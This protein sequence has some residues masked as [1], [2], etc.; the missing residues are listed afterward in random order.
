MISKMKTK[1]KNSMK[2]KYLLLIPLILGLVMCINFVLATEPYYDSSYG[3]GFEGFLNYANILVNG[4]F[5]NVFLALIWIVTVYTL[6]KS[7]WKMPGILSFAFFITFITA[8]IMRLF[9]TSM[10]ELVLFM[11]G[12]G[13]AISVFWAVIMDRT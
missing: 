10:N 9:I 12:V 4:W 8:M 11:L 2:K 13:L 7:E 5:V 6:S 1:T 3:T